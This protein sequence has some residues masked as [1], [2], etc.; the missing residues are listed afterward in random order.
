MKNKPISLI[1]VLCIYIIAFGAGA[2]VLTAVLP[3]IESKQSMQ[4]IHPLVALFIA[5]VTATIVVFIFNLVFKNASV[6]DPYWSVQPIFI[7]G[8][9]YLHYGLSFQLAQLYIL[10][11]LALWSFRLTINWAAGFDNIT[12]EDWRYRDIKTN[13]PKLAQLIVFTGIMLMPTCLVFLGTVPYWYL[14][15][16]E[17]LHAEQLNSIL[18]IIG[19]IIILTGTVFEHLADTSMRRYKKSSNRSAYIDEGLWRY[20]RHPNYLGEI[21]IWV[22]IFIAG[23]V[24][25]HY[26]SLAGVILIIILFTCISIPMME[27]H[28]LKKNAEYSVYQKTVWPLIFGPR[29]SE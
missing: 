2:F 20:S 9:M 19:G 10:V 25:L 21:L 13:Y 17:L 27:R 14:L 15:Q 23:L 6:Y 18:L 24:N 16:V 11:P 7:I 5:N 28:M 8:A 26:F 29:K 12:W 3:L 4:S 22:G 1:I